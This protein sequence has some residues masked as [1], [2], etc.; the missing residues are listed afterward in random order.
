[1]AMY[2]KQKPYILTE[3]PGLREYCGCGLTESAPY[4]DGSHNG[5]GFGKR[6]YLVKYTDTK[7]VSICGCGKSGNLPFCDG[8]HQNREG[9]G[10]RE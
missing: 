6:P 7:T 5:K 4:C 8:S 10:R 9:V 1:M 3:E 2:D